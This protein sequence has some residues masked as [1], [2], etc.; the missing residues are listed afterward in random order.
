M[1]GGGF[2]SERMSLLYQIAIHLNNPSFVDRQSGCD[3]WRFWKEKGWVSLWRSR[4]YI[5]D[6]CAGGR[7]VRR[8]I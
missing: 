3:V 6:A 8:R 7:T 5:L 1:E 4:N 2:R